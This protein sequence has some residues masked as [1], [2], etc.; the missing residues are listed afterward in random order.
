MKKHRVLELEKAMG[1]TPEP[2]IFETQT[3]QDLQREIIAADKANGITP[4]PW[5]GKPINPATFLPPIW[6]AIREGK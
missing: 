4:E 2:I 3:L 5:S 6:K 1:Y